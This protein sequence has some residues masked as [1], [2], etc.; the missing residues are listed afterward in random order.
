MMQPVLLSCGR[1]DERLTVGG[2]TNI[3]LVVDSVRLWP[4][5]FFKQEELSLTEKSD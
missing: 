3:S 2:E 4:V 1:Q 5:F